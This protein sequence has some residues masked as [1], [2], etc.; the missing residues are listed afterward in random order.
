MSNIHKKNAA[1]IAIIAV[2]VCCG[3]VT[4]KAEKAPAST[5]PTPSLTLAEQL[6]DSYGRIKTLSCEIRKTT[7]SK[8]VTVRLLSRV[9]Y[10]SPDHIHVDNASPIKRTI[11]ADGKKLYYYQK[12]MPRGYSQDISKLSPTW[13]RSLHNI[14][15]TPVEHL[16]PL[17]GI[18]EDKLKASETHL[19]R[20]YMVKN[21]YVVIETDDQMRINRIEFFKSAAMQTK[22]AEYI[23]SS[24]QEVL[25]R[26]WIPT[27][28]K[29]TLYLPNEETAK[30]SRV[31]ANLAVNKPI[32]SKLFSYEVFMPKVEFTS[33]FS[34]TYEK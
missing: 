13:L 32:P 5:A 7:K 14:P 28:H 16:L 12:G 2:L 30:E 4:A 24:Q 26:C 10:Q 25:P 9:H 11:I 33:D 22:T 31:I 20:G 15:A 3:T 23:Y 18:K 17:R 19:R 6:L 27:H 8:G 21:L 34:K 29:A 1:R